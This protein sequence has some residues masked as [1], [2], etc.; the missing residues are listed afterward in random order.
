MGKES[1]LE[2]GHFL[3]TQTRE[4]ESWILVFPSK[5]IFVG[6]IVYCLYFRLMTPYRLVQYGDKEIFLRVL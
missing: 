4:F 5:Y 1:F 3:Q 6:G 2:L